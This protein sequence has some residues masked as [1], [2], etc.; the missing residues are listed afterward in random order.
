M[1]NFARIYLDSGRAA[2]ITALDD[3]GNTVATYIINAAGEIFETDRHG[4]SKLVHEP[5]EGH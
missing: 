1:N 5:T 4:V 3:D 2:S